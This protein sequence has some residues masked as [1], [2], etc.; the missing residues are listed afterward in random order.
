VVDSIS[1]SRRWRTAREGHVTAITDDISE[2]EKQ[3]KL[4]GPRFE[5]AWRYFDFHAKQRTTMFNFFVLFSG[6][7]LNA[8]F[9]LLQQRHYLLLLISSLL[10][11]SVTILFIFLERRNEELVHVAEDVLRWVEK[12]ILF[13]DFNR[14]IEWPHQRTWLGIMK[15]TPTTK[16]LGIFIRQDDDA[17]ENRKSKYPHGIWLPFIHVAIALAYVFLAGYSVYFLGWGPAGL[18]VFASAFASA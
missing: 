14:L 6:L 2:F 16:A 12:D 3:W 10:G 5:Y 7:F 18:F 1:T 17:H 11:A 4:Y 13:K 15:G 8:C 9:L